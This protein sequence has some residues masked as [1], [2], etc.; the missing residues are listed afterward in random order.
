MA[1]VRITYYGMEGEGKNL[2]E[3]K[4]D[5]GRKIEA[6]FSGNY[7][8]EI[9]SHRGYAIL[10]AR[11][12]SGWGARIIVDPDGIRDGRVWISGQETYEDAKRGA[13]T[14]LAQLGW[15]DA[16]GKTPPDFLK[17][18]RAIADFVSWAEFQLRYIEGRN[19]GIPESDLHDYASRNPWRPEVWQV[20]ETAVA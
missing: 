3:A 10:L 18:R 19:R 1:T 15:Q 14:H 8:P 2:T 12:P 6:A 5:A 16:D 11:E 4:R 9:L 17:D 13:L 7:T 20:A